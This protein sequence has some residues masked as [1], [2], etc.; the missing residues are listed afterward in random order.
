MRI[1]GAFDEVSAM[2]ELLG[3]PVLT[4]TLGKSA[5]AETHELAA[6]PIGYTGLPLAN[7][8]LGMADTV[9]VVAAG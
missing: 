6:G 3:A 1:A 9:L 4:S 8:T 7:D 2:A 5:I